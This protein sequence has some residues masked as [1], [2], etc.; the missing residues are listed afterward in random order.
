MTLPWQNLPQMVFGG[1][2]HVLPAPW[3]DRVP[4]SFTLIATKD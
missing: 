2:D 4:L 1:T 3:T